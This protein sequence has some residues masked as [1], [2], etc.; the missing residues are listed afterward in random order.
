MVSKNYLCL[1]STI[2]LI[3]I[4]KRKSLKLCNDFLSTEIIVEKYSLTVII[5]ALL[6]PLHIS[7]GNDCR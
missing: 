6:S 4:D 7:I 1:L 2:F 3:F 5:H